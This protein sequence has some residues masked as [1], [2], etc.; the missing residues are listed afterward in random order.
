MLVSSIALSLT[1][2]IWFIIAAQTILSIGIVGLSVVLTHQLH[3]QLPS[4]VRAGASSTV[5]TMSI[6]ILVPLAIIFGLLASQRSV[7]VANILLI[8]VLLI[9]LGAI[10][11]RKDFLKE[12]LL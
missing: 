4:R 10:I 6:I 3:D 2:L 5:S 11:F 9:A 1:H 7:F 12:K 8:A